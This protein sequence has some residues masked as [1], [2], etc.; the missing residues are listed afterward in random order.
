MRHSLATLKPLS[1][2]PISFGEQVA[3]KITPV[4]RCL[5]KKMQIAGFDIPDLLFIFSALS[6]LNFVFGRTDFK[7]ALVWLPTLLLA[8]VLRLGKRGKPENYLLHL[9]RYHLRKKQ[10]FAFFDATPT[11]QCRNEKRK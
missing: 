5:D 8:A 9:F 3:L 7:I 4:S 2:R 10:L 6:V 1:E 11:P